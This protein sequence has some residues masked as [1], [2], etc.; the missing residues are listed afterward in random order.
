MEV[1]PCFNREVI[2]ELSDRA[3]T[4][5]LELSAWA[6]GEKGL[7]DGKPDHATVYPFTDESDADVQLLKAAVSGNLAVL[8]DW[9]S[10][11]RG[12]PDATA[13]LTRT[14]LAAI[15]E[16]PTDALRLILDTDV[17]DIGAED[18]INERNALHEAAIAGREQILEQALSQGVDVGREDVYGRIPL[19]YA[20]MHGNVSIVAQ[21]LKASPESIDRPDHDNFTP[22]IHGIVHHRLECV[23][24]LLAHGAR[25]NPVR[26]T[27]HVPLNLACQYGSLSIAQRLLERGAAIVPDAEGLYPQHLV[28]RKGGSSDIFLVLRQHGAD[29]DQRDKVDQWTP[30]FHAASEG[31]VACVQVLLENGANGNVMDEKGLSPMYYATWEGHLSCMKLITAACELAPGLATPSSGSQRSGRWTTASVGPKPLKDADGIPTLS[32]PPPIIPLR[33]YGHNFLEQKALIQITLESQNSG[34]VTFYDDNKYPAARLTI[35]SK[36]SE[37]I[38]RNIT[39]PIPDELRT[40][41]F[42]VDSLDAFAIDFDIFPTFGA[43]VIARTVALPTVFGALHSS[44]GHCCLPLFDPRLRAIGQLGFRFQ[45]I[46]PFDGIPAEIGTTETYWKATSH[47]DTDP[48]TLVT[49]SS[50]SGAYVR[51]YVQL[52][53]DGVPVLCPRW[54][55]DYHDLA[56]PVGRLTFPQFERLS[57][58]GSDR[59]PLSNLGSHNDPV[60]IFTELHRRACTLQHALASLDR[61]VRVNIHVLYPSIAE[62]HHLGLGVA[63]NINAFADAILTVVFEHARRTRDHGD[64]RSIVFSSYNPDFCAALNWKQPSCECPSLL[65]P[66]RPAS[67]GLGKCVDGHFQILYCFATTSAL[68]MTALTRL[69]ERRVMVE[70]RLPSKKRFGL[71]KQTISWA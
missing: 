30:L 67:M 4:N 23:E 41:S 58:G 70:T 65:M 36:S 52:T 9:T 2:S 55:I 11:L 71:P 33:R 1:Q 46:R 18:E 15:S 39:L 56:C 50:L 13:R 19:H 51:L 17:V 21:L 45:V 37:L 16:A 6:E 57:G 59:Q 20:C 48:N 26:E 12:A 32:L 60:Q 25:I 66:L 31:Y 7:F 10:R 49:G 38:P 8:K 62:E 35:S 22:L 14:F 27:D 24:V 34:A 29:L 42:Q 63:L 44:S 3:T 69:G 43:K 64:V 54:C 40:L 47:L 68:A 53:A 5:L 61:S 28:A